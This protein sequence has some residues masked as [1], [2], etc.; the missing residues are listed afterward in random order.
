MIF[1]IEDRLFELFPGLTVGVLVARVD[2]T[3]YGDD[4]L[5]SS[6]A[7]V[8][9]A[10]D[11]HNIEEHPNIT[12]WQEA[13]AKAGMSDGLYES[14]VES[15]LVRALKRG[16]FPRVNP[17]VDLCVSASLEF[18][19]PVGS[20]DISTLEGDICLGFAKGH[21][22][23]T[24]MEGGEDE[25]AAKGEVIYRDDRSVLTRG[26]VWRQSRKGR[27]SADSR[28]VFM[29]I[30][31]MGGLSA[32]LANGVMDRIGAYLHENGSG[33]VIHRDIVTQHKTLVEFT[34]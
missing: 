13:F 8:R 24:P 20:H 26:W 4:V 5:E 1:S 23:F 21:E 7:L 14:S 11:S 17:L 9:A 2:N 29:P 22:P 10:F 28:T 16:V 33:E 15:L 3:R 32:T 12:A 25:V 19:V 6:L 27:V 30:D 34:T 18:L 31:I